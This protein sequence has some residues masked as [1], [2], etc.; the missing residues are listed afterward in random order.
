MDDGP[1][2][3]DFCSIC[4]SNFNIPCQANCS[5]WYCGNCILQVWRHGSALQPCKCPLCRRPINLLI[6]TEAS[7][8][9][10]HIPD[11]R[12]IIGQ[13]EAYN[14]SFGGRAT[15][16]IQR[17]RD[18]PFLLR[19]L[20]HDLIDPRRSLPL[21]IKARVYLATILSAVYFLSP[22]DIIPEGVLGL[23]GF[24]DDLIILLMCALYVA[25]VYRSVLV[26]RHGGS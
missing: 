8:Q 4:H 9:Q 5:H 14:R 7:L 18:L 15:G 20:L 16:I 12:L 24:L 22:V 13:I 17:L 10:R 11:V 25:A 3:N 23:I 19:R 1:P 21:V 26:F 6:P 2:E